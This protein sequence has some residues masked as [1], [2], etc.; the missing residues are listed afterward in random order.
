[1]QV[2]GEL[3]HG[4]YA[5]LADAGWAW[6]PHEE[7]WDEFPEGTLVLLLEREGVSRFM[8]EAVPSA[9]DVGVRVWGPGDEERE[10]LAAEVRQ[11]LGLSGEP[12][13][14]DTTWP[15]DEDE[16][17]PNAARWDDAALLAAAERAPFP[18]YGLTGGFPGTRDLG[19]LGRQG[20]V[21]NQVTLS[22]GL[23][24]D[25]RVDVTVAGPLRGRVR[26]HE[27][28]IDPLPTIATELLSRAG[29]RFTTRDELIHASDEIVR[30]GYE[31]GE[32]RV[33]GE[34]R[35]FSFLRDGVHWVALHDLPA[36]HLLYVVAGNVEPSEIELT[37]LDDLTGYGQ[38]R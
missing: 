31:D 7:A 34:P 16:A 8:L 9:P 27:W 37:R 24:T 14:L 35:P 1:M 6:E 25:A 28:S 10:R 20:E 13:S 18:L 29:A 33:D 19:G 22:H 21:V 11:G 36:G 12:L 4:V 23:R 26:D 32:I 17:L 3:D 15:D 5:R 38:R 2:V 30:R